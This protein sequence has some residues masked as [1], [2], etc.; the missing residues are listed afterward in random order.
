MNYLT[1]NFHTPQTLQKAP[2]F[3]LNRGNIWLQGLSESDI[4][5]LETRKSENDNI[6]KTINRQRLLDAFSP[7]KSDEDPGL[8]CFDSSHIHK[9]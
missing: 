1:R 3:L 5:F 6:L 9:P 2:D 8:V 4:E 7:S